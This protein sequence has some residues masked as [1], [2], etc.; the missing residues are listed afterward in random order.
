MDL[1][2]LFLAQTCLLATTAAMLWVSRSDADRGSGMWTWRIAITSQAVAYLVL[3]IPATG[4][5]A[6]ATGLLA[7]LAGAVSVALFF[8]GIRRFTGLGFDMLPLAAMVAAV[9]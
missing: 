6:I 7:N 4:P 8:I 9:T 5:A 2:T 1:H 3:A